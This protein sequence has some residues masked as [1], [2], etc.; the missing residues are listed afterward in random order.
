MQRFKEKAFSE[1]ERQKIL[2]RS[3]MRLLS[4][5]LF[6]VILIPWALSVAPAGVLL[7]GVCVCVGGW[8][9]VWMCGCVGVWVCLVITR[10]QRLTHTQ[11]NH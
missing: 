10:A 4:V 2:T 9:W 7:A 11:P 8:V 3:V 5:L 1:T 6:V